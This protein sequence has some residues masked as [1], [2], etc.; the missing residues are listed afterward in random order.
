M[1]RNELSDK[2]EVESRQMF[3]LKT[4]NLMLEQKLKHATADLKTMQGHN[5]AFQ[6]KIQKYKHKLRYLTK[7]MK[8]IMDVQ[9]RNKKDTLAGKGDN[10]ITSAADR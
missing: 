9:N 10:Q 1:L 5:E 2:K 6:V 8:N 3:D 7:Y 4:C